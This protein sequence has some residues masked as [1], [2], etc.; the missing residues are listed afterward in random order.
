MD[1]VH[2]VEAYSSDAGEWPD[3]ALR[4]GVAYLRS[5]GM[6]K[7]GYFRKGDWV[8][9]NTSEASLKVDVGSPIGLRCFS[10]FYLP[11]SNEVWRHFTGCDFRGRD[12]WM[13]AAALATVARLIA[14]GEDVQ[15][16]VHFL[17]EAVSAVRH[18]QARYC[19][20][21]DEG[22]VENSGRLLKALAP[23]DIEVLENGKFQRIAFLEPLVSASVSVDLILLVDTSTSVLEDSATQVESAVRHVAR[24]TMDIPGA[25]VTLFTFNSKLVRFTGRAVTEP[26]IEEAASCLCRPSKAAEPSCAW[27]LASFQLRLPARRAADRRGSS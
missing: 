24:A 18:G 17:F 6:P 1:S 11:E 22:P 4:D 23:D 13:N 9:A 7:P 5:L 2:A 10:L 14:R 15:T 27:S 16:G 20:I 19:H 3:S 25:E 8:R 26:E 21:V 12:Y